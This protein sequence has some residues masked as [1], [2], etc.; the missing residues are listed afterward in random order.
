[1]TVAAEASRQRQRELYGAPLADIAARLM[2]TLGLNQSRLAH[3]LGLSA[4]MLSQLLSGQRVKIGNPAVVHRLQALSDLADIAAGLQ[5]EEVA[6]RLDV[7]RT[8][9]ATITTRTAAGSV[10]PTLLEGLRSLA[11]SAEL[12][13]A[14]DLIDAEG[15]SHLAAAMRDAARGESGGAA[16]G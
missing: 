13:R 9:Q 2:T 3:A 12:T 1:M 4:P 15:I 16:S 6:R 14:A 7:I 8:E 11:T 10:S 5:D